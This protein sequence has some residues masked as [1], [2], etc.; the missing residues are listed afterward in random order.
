MIGAFPT[1]GSVKDWLG[2]VYFLMPESCLTEISRALN[3]IA[4]Y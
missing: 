4:W 2:R 1:Q 3:A